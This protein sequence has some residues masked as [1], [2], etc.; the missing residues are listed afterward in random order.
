MKSSSTNWRKRVGPLFT[1]L[2][3]AD[4]DWLPKAAQRYRSVVHAAGRHPVAA[5]LLRHLL[6]ADHMSESIEGNA[7]KSVPAWATLPAAAQRHLIRRLGTIACAPYL[8]HVIDK[9]GLEK[10]RRSIDPE[11]HREALATRE[12][13]VS[14][15]LRREFHS[16]LESD[17]LGAFVAAVGL[18]LVRQ[19]VANE[20]R[21][22]LFRLKYL[23][24]R[25]AWRAPLPE[26]SCDHGQ[27]IA[28]LTA[29]VE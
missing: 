25:L 13:L 5:K 22:L 12:R 11:C 8:R 21:F 16:A 4:H 6:P 10:V 24:P 23:F 28:L 1:P 26:L 27:L 3:F 20:Q 19:T 29:D 7:L 17:Q 9:S 18:A 14:T 2:K 15:D